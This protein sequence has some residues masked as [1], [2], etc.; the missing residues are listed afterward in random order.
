MTVFLVLL[1]AYLL[2]SVVF[3]VIY[4]HLRGDDVRG[5][6]MPGGSGMFR[7]YGLVPAVTISVL[8]ILKGVLAAYLA[9]HFAPGWEWAAMFLV[10][11]GHCYPVFFRFNGG[12]GI[13]PMLGALLIVA[14]KT[15]LL[16]V[17]LSLIVMPLYKATIQKRVGLNAIPF[18]SAVVLPISV[19]A[20]FWLGGTLALVA[21]GLGMAVRS[22]QL[23]IEDGKLGKKP[24]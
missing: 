18:M 3:G 24:A 12:G 9:L 16:M 22:V 15:L 7:Q 23:L 17:L 11:I 4:S 8:D 6:D 1:S 14:P 5:R 13:A 21:G 20:S 2:G 10:I 19:A